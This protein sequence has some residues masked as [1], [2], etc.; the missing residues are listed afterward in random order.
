MSEHG[1]SPLAAVRSELRDGRLQVVVTGALDMAA[2][3]R[4]E[5]A[6][7]ALLVA[8]DAESVVLDLGQVTFVDSAG[9]GAL[10]S[11][12]ERASQL[13]IELTAARVSASVRRILEVTGIGDLTVT[14]GP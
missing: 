9:L 3:F 2:A 7:E 14:S 10:L 8:G 1:I 11:I 12:R 4:F 13:G 6:L 5:S